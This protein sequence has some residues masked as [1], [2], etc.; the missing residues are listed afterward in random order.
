VRRS[1]PALLSPAPKTGAQYVFVNRRT[2]KP[3]NNIFKT[4]GRARTKAGLTDVRFHD[5][6]HTFLT[7]L[8]DSGADIGV[9]QL[10]AGH[11]D[12]KITQRYVHPGKVSALE[13]VERMADSPIPSHATVTN[14]NAI[15]PGSE[16]S[17]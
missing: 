12:I 10:I 6:R 7:R 5:L 11:S 2:G 1:D 9:V 14:P 15:S 17:N 13:S 8:V 4:Y 16:S 3:Y